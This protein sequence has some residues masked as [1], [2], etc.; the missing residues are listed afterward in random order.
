MEPYRA[1]W[2]QPNRNRGRIVRRR[3]TVQIG[4]TFAVG[5]DEGVSGSSPEEGSA[6]SRGNRDSFCRPALHE[7]QHAVRSTA[8]RNRASEAGAGAHIG[9]LRG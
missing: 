8:C 4:E 3:T 2:S 1:Q 9:R 7:L 5:C 6:K